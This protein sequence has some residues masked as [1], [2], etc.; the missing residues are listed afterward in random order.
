MASRPQ[1]V[2]KT[3]EYIKA[4][5]MQSCPSGDKRIIISDPLF[6]EA[7]GEDKIHMLQL[8]KLMNPPSNHE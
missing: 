5:N 1:A 7:F 6:K 2:K 8:G 3:W 4:N